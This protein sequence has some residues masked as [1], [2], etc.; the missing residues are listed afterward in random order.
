MEQNSFFVKN[1]QTV[2]FST[3]YVKN[4]SRSADEESCLDSPLVE[5]YNALLNYL[6][7]VKRDSYNWFGGF[8]NLGTKDTGVVESSGGSRASSTGGWTELEAGADDTAQEK[9]RKL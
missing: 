9:R 6:D 2:L 8:M 4:T 1:D 7:D 5:Q 3:S